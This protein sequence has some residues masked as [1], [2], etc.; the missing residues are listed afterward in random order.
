[1]KI[2]KM[3]NS[4]SKEIGLEWTPAELTIC[5]PR[6]TAVGEHGTWRSPACLSHFSWPNSPQDYSAK[7]LV[8]PPTHTKTHRQGLI[9]KSVGFGGS[10]CGVVGFGGFW[11]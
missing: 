7:I 9:Q 2:V 10:R 8:A 5:A 1:M 11:W 3:F 6:N 4:F